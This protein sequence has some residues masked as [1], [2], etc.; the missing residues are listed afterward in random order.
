MRVSPKVLLSLAVLL[1]PLLAA[2]CVYYPARP[3]YGAVWVPGHWGGPYGNVW[4]PGHWR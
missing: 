4:I 1:A 2:G 3:Y